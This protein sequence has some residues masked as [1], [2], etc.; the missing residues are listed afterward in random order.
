MK[1]ATLSLV[2][3]AGAA[4]ANPL[5]SRASG[6]Q[7]FDIS[8]YQGTVDFSGAYNAGARFVIIKVSLNGSLADLGRHLG[9]HLDRH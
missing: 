2:L 8:S 6:V 7:G 9:R 5:E 1:T 4:S 3:A